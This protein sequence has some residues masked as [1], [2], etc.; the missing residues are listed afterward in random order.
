M[1]KKFAV[2]TALSLMALSTGAFA[3][4]SFAMFDAKKTM[5]IEGT[6][7]SYEFI[8]PHTWLRVI[9]TDLQGV[10]TEWVMELGSPSQLSRRGWKRNSFKPGDK[11]GVQFHPL[12]SGE[13]GGQFI[14]ATGPDGKPIP[15]PIPAET[16][17]PAGY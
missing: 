2:A 17:T 13:K 1:I 4:H 12:A 15:P 3:H 16:G 5:T 7:K 14:S 11:I 8:N 9:V 6:V 10:Q